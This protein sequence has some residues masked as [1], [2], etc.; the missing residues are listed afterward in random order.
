MYTDITTMVH[1]F[2]L[3]HKESEA[4]VLYSLQLSHLAV[5]QSFNFHVNTTVKL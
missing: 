1:I 5:Y 2:F 3:L 4:A